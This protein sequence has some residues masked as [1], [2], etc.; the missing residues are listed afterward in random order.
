M[1]PRPGL[2]RRM[3]HGLMAV[4]VL[5]ASISWT[6]E[7]VSARGNEREESEPRV[8][9]GGDQ[10][11]HPG[12]IVEL[13]WA[14]ADNVRELEILLS[15]DGGRTYATCISPE[16]DPSLCRFTW[17]VP[18]K[19]GQDLRLRVRYNRDGREIE[20]PP[21]KPLGLEASHPLEGTPLGL[22][23]APRAEDTGREGST[24]V[25]VTEQSLDSQ[26]DVQHSRP[27]AKLA[28]YR[29]LSSRARCIPQTRQN[30]PLCVPLRA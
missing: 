7:P 5:V 16:L 14:R 26:N 17:R 25:T 3:L 2:P 9:L 6:F 1:S 24:C 28:C 13:H 27:A 18:E 4:F 23:A 21:T 12:E 10:A 15:Q 8:V 11:V 30:S 22:P 20:G 29:A 19:I